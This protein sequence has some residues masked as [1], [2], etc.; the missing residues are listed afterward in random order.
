MAKARALGFSATQDTEAS[1]I[2]TFDRLRAERII[3]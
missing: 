1:F 3:P 2:D